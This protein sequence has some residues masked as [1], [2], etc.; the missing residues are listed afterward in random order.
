MDRVLPHLPKLQFLIWHRVV[1]IITH[2]LQDFQELPEMIHTK[3]LEQ[4][5]GHSWL[6]IKVIFYY[7]IYRA[8]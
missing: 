6:Q 8:S 1:G 3:K 7:W 5:L 4:S 2:T